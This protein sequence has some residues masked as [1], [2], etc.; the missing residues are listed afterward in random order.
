MHNYQ[1]K[2]TNVLLGGQMKYD[3]I[4]NN[5]TTDNVYI[6]PISSSVPYNRLEKSDLLNYPHQENI[7]KFYADT[8]NSFYKSFINPLLESIYPLP[9]GYDGPTYDTTYDS[10]CIKEPI[11]KNIYGKTYSILCPLWLEQITEIENLKFKI[12]IRNKEDGLICDSIIQFN[13]NIAKYFQSYIEFLKLHEGCDWVFDINST[14]SVVNGL[15]VS[16]GIC[17]EATLFNI[18]EDLTFR[19]RPLLEFNN[20]IING[21]NNNNMI[22]KQLFNFNLCFNISDIVDSFTNHYLKDDVTLKLSVKTLYKDQELPITE[23]FTN[24]EYIGR[25]KNEAW[26]IESETFNIIKPVSDEK[27]N[28]FDYLLD[29][30]CIDLIDK[31]KISQNTCHWCLSQNPEEHFNI[32]N[33]FSLMKTDEK[34]GG[35]INYYNGETANLEM[36]KM[37]NIYYPYWC[38]TYEKDK[39]ADDDEWLNKWLTELF[40]FKNN[41]SQY[42]SV[43]NADCWVKNNHYRNNEGN[44]NTMYVLISLSSNIEKTKKVLSKYYVEYGWQLIDDETVWHL[45]YCMINDVYYVIIIANKGDENNSIDQILFKNFIK[46]IGSKTDKVCQNLYAILN[47]HVPSS[48]ILKFTKGLTFLRAAGPGLNSREIEYFKS[49][50]SDAIV[51][52][53]FGKIKPY[54]TINNSNYKNYTYEKIKCNDLSQ[55]YYKFA[56]SKFKPKYPSLDYFSIRRRQIDDKN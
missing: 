36:T 19:E 21:L 49:D 30:L 23:L 6:T 33:G 52:R 38:N 55:N 14:K 9:I 4:I 27:H 45:W 31:N 17:A 50:H 26:K 5:R 53:N 8:A 47:S 11:N 16:T 46:T 34:D 29:N 13:S 54:F 41:Y 35:G 25:S 3:L 15:N 7:K 10:N 24:H 42:Y 32:Y 12:E 2:R 43:F 48:K 20:M 1:L 28:V 44:I 40:Q 37:T 22:C 18:F 51:N 56:H 39:K